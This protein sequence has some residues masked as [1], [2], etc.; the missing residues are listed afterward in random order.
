MQV[1][2]RQG[3]SFKRNVDPLPQIPVAEQIAKAEKREAGDITASAFAA[4]LKREIN[5]WD[6]TQL[7]IDANL[8]KFS[9]EES[10]I[11]T[12]ASACLLVYRL[13]DHADFE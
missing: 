1:I 13:L 11:L 2:G 7:V 6:L 5:Y 12:L 9:L 8:G 3:C 4:M 10:D